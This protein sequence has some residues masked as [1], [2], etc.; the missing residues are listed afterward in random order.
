MIKS[1]HPGHS[2]NSF[3]LY[4]GLTDN[5]KL[6]MHPLASLL[7]ISDLKNFERKNKKIK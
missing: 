2:L 5:L 3:N 4:A 7:A 1:H 6:R